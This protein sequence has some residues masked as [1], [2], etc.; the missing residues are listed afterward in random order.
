MDNPFPGMDPWLE[1]YCPDVHSSLA[2]YIR[3]TLNE[4]LPPGLRASVEEHVRIEEDGQETGFRP[5][6]SVS[7]TD[8]WGEADLE[9]DPLRSEDSFA[10]ALLVLDDPEVDRS[11][12]VV[13]S[14]GQLVTSIEILSASNKNTM[15]G[16]F[17][18]RRKQ[19]TLVAAGVH[20]VEIDLLRGGEFVCYADLDQVPPERRGTYYVC[21]T[22]AHHGHEHRLYPFALRERLGVIPVPL[23]QGEAP[24]SLDLQM[25]IDQCYRRGRYGDAINYEEP[26]N[27]PLADREQCWAR[28]VT[29]LCR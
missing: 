5:D 2:V 10:P 16:R 7:E 24:I 20:L 21:L 28:D 27:P 29:R 3:D 11:V 1:G 25:V 12:H 17:A 26:P 18:Y 6:V 15:D 13:T 14:K 23:R 19:R 4:R 22:L 8:A 9:W